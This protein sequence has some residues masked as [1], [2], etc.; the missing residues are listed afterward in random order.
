MIFSEMS[1]LDNLCIKAAERVPSLWLGTAQRRIIRDEYREYIGGSIDAD[2][3]L[4]LPAESLYDLVY[5]RE[6]IYNPQILII[7]RP[8]IDTDI[9]LRLHI[10][11][12]IAMFKMRGTTILI[13]DSS[14]TDSEAVS[15][16]VLIVGG[17]RITGEK[18]PKRKEAEG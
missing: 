15:D 9:R 4:G 3:P 11:S 5:L 10:M 8:F 2:S 14:T 12:L 1:Y 6:Y 17:G 18:N 13:M 16:R 7:E